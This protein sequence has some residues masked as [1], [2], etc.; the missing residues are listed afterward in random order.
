[1]CNFKQD[2]GRPMKEV[3]EPA[4]SLSQVDGRSARAL[5]PEH[6]RK[7][8]RAARTERER[9]VGDEDSL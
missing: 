9:T 8:R 2:Q 5:R 4:L 6:A 3:R 1:M 7:S